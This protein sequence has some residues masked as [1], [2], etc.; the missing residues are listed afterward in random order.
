LIAKIFLSLFPL[1]YDIG[2]AGLLNFFLLS[3]AGDGGAD[4]DGGI[5]GWVDGCV[6]SLVAFHLIICVVYSLGR[7][8]I[9]CLQSSYTSV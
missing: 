5:E 3:G 7:L 8:S 1:L 9:V 2:L 6:W 4:M